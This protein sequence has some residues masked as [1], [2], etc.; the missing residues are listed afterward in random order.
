[1]ELGLIFAITILSL[2]GIYSLLVR[3]MEG[4]KGIEKRPYYGKYS[5]K[6]HT[7]KKSREKHIV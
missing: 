6:L 7:A 2:A 1:M 5:G 3:D 4:T